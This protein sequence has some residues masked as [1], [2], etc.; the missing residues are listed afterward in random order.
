MRRPV[1]TYSIVARDDT[2]G[3]LGVAVQSHWFSVGS[4]VSW[5]AAGVGAIATQSF[6]EPAYGPRGL[7]LMRRGLS[8]PQS[9]SALLGQDAE[10]AV[11]QVA[12]VDAEGRVAAHTGDR[13]IRHAG[14]L[15]GPGFSVQA[16][17]MLTN[18]V[19]PAMGAAYKASEGPLVER[20]L[21]ALEAAEAAGGDIRGRQSAAVLVVAAEDSGRPWLD[22]LIDLRIEDHATPLKELRR[23]V[24][25]HQAYQAMTRGDEALARGE[26]DAARAAYAEAAELLPGHDELVFWRAITE[27]QAGGL[28]AAR[29][30]LAPLFA[31]EPRWAELLD[32]LPAAGVITEE[33]AARLG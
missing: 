14:H 24:R 29:A 11:R 1:H 26:K 31:R 22:T 13:C 28:D 33:L 4:V 21:A 8:A 25:A 5:A 23:L 10:G 19:V 2:S 16:N 20:L 9:L 12:F 32:R 27:A 18:T 15:M 3:Q 7:D 17:M 30:A 6:A